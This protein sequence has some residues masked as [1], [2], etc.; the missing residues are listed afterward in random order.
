[1]AFKY[2]YGL[3]KECLTFSGYWL[4][5]SMNKVLIIRSENLIELNF[6]LRNQ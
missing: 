5:K 4:I 6:L 2:S 3:Q 1:M